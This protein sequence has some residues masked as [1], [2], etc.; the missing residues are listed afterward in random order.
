MENEGKLHIN[1]HYQDMLS[2]VFLGCLIK[3]SFN[4]THV[5]LWMLF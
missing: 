1:S 5:A 3:S 4:V 2:E